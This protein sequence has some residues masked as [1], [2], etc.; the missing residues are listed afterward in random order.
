MLSE[1]RK[2]PGPLIF[3]IKGNAL[4]DGPGIRSVVFFKGCPLSCSWCH[5]PEGRRIRSEIGY[6]RKECIG[7]GACIAV[8]PVKAVSSVH[9]HHVDRSKCTLCFQCVDACPAG[10]LSRVGR[11]MTVEEIVKEVVKDKPFFDTSGGGATFSGGEP[12]LFMEFLSDLLKRLKDLRIHTLLETSGFFDFEKFEA[13]LL[14]WLDMIYY[15]IKILDNDAHRRHTGVPNQRILDN[16]EK[17]SRTGIFLLPRTPLVPG[18]TDTPDNILAIAR[19][20]AKLHIKSAALLAYNP[21]WHDKMSKIGGESPYRGDKVMTSWMDPQ[22]IEHCR[23]IFK[24]EGI[25]VV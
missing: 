17:L 8:C 1:E 9:I 11:E 12:T 24:E 18:M 14:P 5:N 6:D 15:D 21:L 20:L 16:F 2:A 13:L 19:Y 22:V 25:A 23:N 7:C 4:D 3:E 10:A